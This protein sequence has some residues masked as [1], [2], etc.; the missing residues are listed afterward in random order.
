[1]SREKIFVAVCAL[2]MVA[3]DKDQE[4]PVVLVHVTGSAQ[5]EKDVAAVANGKVGAVKGAKADA[6]VTGS[7]K[8]GEGGFKLKLVVK[9]R[10]G[11]VLSRGEYSLKKQRLDEDTQKALK[12]D[13]A[14]ALPAAFAP[15]PPPPPQPE[16]VASALPPSSETMAVA[17]VASEPTTRPAWRTMVDLSGGLE[18]IGRS[19]ATSNT[20][21]PKYSGGM[22]PG[23]RLDAALYPLANRGRKW[24]MIGADVRYERA[25]GFDSTAANGVKAGTTEDAFGVGLRG[26]WILREDEMSP[27]MGA[28][29]GF[30]QRRFGT[31]QDLGIP[32]VSYKF[33]ELGALGRFP[34]VSPRF[35]IAA[36]LAYQ[37]VLDSGYINDMASYG[38]GGANGVRIEGGAEYLPADKLSLR[39]GASYAR[40]GLS[41]D[42]IGMR[43]ATS[44]T[45]SYYGAFATVGYLY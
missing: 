18:M 33:I 8:K 7:V 9:D 32:G 3:A 21:D 34:I 23:F 44:A 30:G 1:M 6:T 41:F 16:P 13:L 37:A 43:T 27:V 11:K 39:L 35:A 10:T 29:V 15:P 38:P 17:T 24:A 20:A 36:Q 5:V 31:D 45:D 40:Y 22:V 4:K 28:R 42:G 12:Q 25:V 26:R 2:L 19:F 14:Q